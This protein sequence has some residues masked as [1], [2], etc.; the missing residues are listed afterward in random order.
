MNFVYCDCRFEPIFLLAVCEP[1]GIGPLVRVQ[2][3][4]DRAG[5]GTKFAL[6]RVRIGFKR[7]KISV[8]AEDFVFVDGTCSDFGEEKFPDAGRAARAHGMDAAVPMIHVSDDADSVRGGGPDGEVG[9]GYACHG[10]EMRA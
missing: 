1:C 5:V 10:V 8:W 7:E 4:Y 2:V 9:S 3:G 6:K